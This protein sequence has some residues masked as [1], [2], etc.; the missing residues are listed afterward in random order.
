MH[1]Q[2]RLPAEGVTWRGCGDEVVVLDLRSATYLA[3]NRTGADLWGRLQAGVTADELAAALGER[4]SLARPHAESDV[5]AFLAVL[6]DHDLLER[7]EAAETRATPV[8]AERPAGYL[9]PAVS[10]LGTL[11]ELTHGG[12]TGPPDGFGSAGDTGSIP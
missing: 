11:A 3:V 4:W 2:V 12:T 10:C 7:C 1:R 8:D 5:A 9:P 6:D